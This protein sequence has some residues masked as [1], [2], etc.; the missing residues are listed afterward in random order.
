[1][2][3]RISLRRLFRL[4]TSLRLLAIGILLGPPLWLSLV[5]L[6]AKIA[7]VD[8]DKNGFLIWSVTSLGLLL[9]TFVVLWGTARVFSNSAELVQNKYNATISNIEGYVRQYVETSIV[10]KSTEDEMRRLLLP[11]LKTFYDSAEKEIVILGADVLR[12]ST[13]KFNELQDALNKQQLK[14]TDRLYYEYGFVFNRILAASS[15][16]LLRRFIYLF[17]PS[18]LKERTPDFQ[19][20]YI[21][22]LNDQVSFF[23]INQNYTII[24]TP[25]ATVWGAPK[26]MIFFQNTIAEVFFKGGGIVIT[27]GTK[28][29]NSVV[30]ATRKSLIE[31]YVDARQGAP[32]RSEY[33]QLNLAEFETYIS[34]IRSYV[35]NLRTMKQ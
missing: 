17:E 8:I 10:F 5:V 28:A 16:K 1:V 12:P 21:G 14:T 34:N 7:S 31:D 33:S 32:A 24:R 23:R 26:S 4:R 2:I 35:S 27:S 29:T 15:Q 19:D 20:R 11:D 30:A 25:R 6:L 9:S 13:I 22:W 3:T 18:E